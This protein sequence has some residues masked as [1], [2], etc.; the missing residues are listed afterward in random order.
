VCVGVPQC[1]RGTEVQGAEDCVSS[2]RDGDGIPN[3]RDKCPDQPE[4]MNGFQDDDGCPDEPQRMVALK[5]EQERKEAAAKEESERAAEA[6]EKAKEE[7]QREKEAREKQEAA[8]ALV[9]KKHAEWAQNRGPRGTRATVGLGLAGAGVVGGALAGL[10]AAISSGK[11]DSIRHGGLATGADIASAA[12]SAQTFST[13][14]EVSAVIGAVGLGVGLPLWLA[15]LPEKEPPPP[16]LVVTGS[17]AA[18][19]VTF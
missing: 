17:G 6:A 2:D 5:V 13:A 3:S 1:P 11:N 15:N 9:E 4:D 10:F 12:S 14:A 7:Q 19:V 8:M 18:I 16:A